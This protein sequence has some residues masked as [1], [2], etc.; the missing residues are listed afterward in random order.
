LRLNHAVV[1]LECAAYCINYASKLDEEA[2]SCSL[3]DAAVMQSD[4]GVEQI[5][6]ERPQPRQRA[7]LV[8]SGKLAVSGYVRRKDGREF[9]G[10]RH[11][12]P[13]PPARIARMPG[14]LRHVAVGCFVT[15]PGRGASRW[16]GGKSRSPAQQ[17]Q[18]GFSDG[19][20][21]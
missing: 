14:A 11:S 12:C 1:H 21:L 20:L 3:N 16:Q 19:K 9:A 13:S 2:I 8:G 5:A 17:D 6:A 4:G 15:H 10:F 7:I 18:R